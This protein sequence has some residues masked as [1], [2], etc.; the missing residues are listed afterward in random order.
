MNKESLLKE[1][2]DKGY[3][4]SYAANLNFA[5]YD[6]VTGWPPKVSFISLAISVIGLIWPEISTYW[7][8][9][10]I[11]LL[12]I[13][14]IYTERYSKSINSYGDRGKSNTR[15]WNELKELYYTVKESRDENEFTEEIAKLR[16]ISNEFNET[17]EYDQIFFANWYAHYKLFA[18][19]D[20][21][22]MD[23][24]LQ[25]GFW[26]DKIPASMKSYIYLI[27]LFT[28]ILFCVK[29]SCIA[30]FFTSLFDF[31]SNN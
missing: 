30:N 8:T 19:K 17:S 12:S 13:A 1:I 6:I 31:C 5:T 25:F 18:E 4:V 2:A 23:E 28:I 7:I 29:C 20:Y 24:Q 26:K 3:A 27:I 14:C 15:Q 16:S 22:W 10:P 21:R 11:L 9:V